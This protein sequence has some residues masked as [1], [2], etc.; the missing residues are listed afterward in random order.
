ME[1]QRVNRICVPSFYSDE[2]TSTIYSTMSR[3]YELVGIVEAMK[4]DFFILALVV[5]LF[6]ISINMGVVHFCL[7][8]L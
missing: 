3:G 2:G 8:I 7:P 6:S 4:C 5:I 1:L